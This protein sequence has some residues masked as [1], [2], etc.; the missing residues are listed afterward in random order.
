[1]LRSAKI[2]VPELKNMMIHTIMVD[3]MMA[4]NIMAYEING[5]SCCLINSGGGE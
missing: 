4:C 3:A 2:R 5:L 1:M